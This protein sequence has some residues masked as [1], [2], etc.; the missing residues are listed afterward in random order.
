MNTKT[1]LTVALALAAP[2]AVMAGE[3]EMTNTTMTSAPMAPPQHMGW[4]LGGGV[5]YMIDA[6]EPFFNGH[7]GYDFGNGSSLFLESGWMGEE[8]FI[9]PLN[10]DVDIV[11]ITLNYKYEHMFTDRFGLYAGVGAGSSLVDISAGLVSDDDWVFTAQAFAGLVY[12]VSDN[13]EIYAGGRYM[14]MDDVSIFGANIDD[15]DD[16]GVGAG[17][18]FNF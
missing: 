1:A 2:S 15:L 9:F 3:A 13:F 7:L 12:N 16:V 11:P 18:R 6:E 10:I 14:W 17:I 5:D 8:E 4:Y